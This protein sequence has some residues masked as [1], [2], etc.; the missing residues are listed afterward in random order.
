MEETLSNKD[1]DL[2]EEIEIAK[3]ESEFLSIY[4]KMPPNRKFCF[5]MTEKSPGIKL[6]NNRLTAM[7]MRDSTSFVN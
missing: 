7:Y 1:W 2:M 4:R 3:L 6:I 5:S